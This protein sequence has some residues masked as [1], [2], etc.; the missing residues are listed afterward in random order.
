[1][2]PR[3]RPDRTA[4]VAGLVT[5]GL[6]ALFLA[7]QLGTIDVGFGYGLPALLAGVGAILLA[8]GL[9]GPRP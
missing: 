8:S 1:V 9:E 2:T 7:D 4:L 6:G 5:V 3:R